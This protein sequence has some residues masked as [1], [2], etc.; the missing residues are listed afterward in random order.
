MQADEPCSN[1]GFY[2]KIVLRSGAPEGTRGVREWSSMADGQLE[3]GV[4]LNDRY[5]ILRT[6][7]QG[8]MGTVYQA[9]HERLSAILAVKEI[10]GLQATGTAQKATLDQYEQEARF[11]VRLNHPNLPKV[12]DAFVDHDRFYLVME[13]VEGVTL[14]ARFKELGARPMDP[15]KVVEWGLQIADVLAYLHSQQPPIIFRDLKPSN[16]MVQPDGGIKLID[17]GIARRFQPGADKDTSLLGSVGYSPPEQFG[18]HQTDTRSD[19]YAFGATLHHLLTAR[20]PSQT[21]FKF[22]PAQQLNPAVPE[23]L[24]KLLAQCLAME[25]DQR[26]PN[27]HLVASGLLGIRDQLEMQQRHI[28]D[29]PHVAEPGHAPS[30]KII[31][32]KLNAAEKSRPKRPAVGH[33][34]QNGAVA[35]RQTPATTPRWGRIGIAVVSLGLILGGAAFGLHALSHSRSGPRS[36]IQ[37]PPS[38][39]PGKNE[40]TVFAGGANT[41]GGGGNGGNSSSQNSTDPANGTGD[42]QKHVDVPTTAG[43][44]TKPFYCKAE[45]EGYSND[46]KSVRIHVT[47]LVKGEKGT[48]G[49]VAAYFYTADKTPL[50]AVNAQSPFA[51]KSGQLYGT[52]TFQI[53]ADEEPF[54]GTM[55]IP[56]D[57]FPSTDGVQF[58]CIV[59]ADNQSAGQTEMQPLKWEDSTDSSKPRGDQSGVRFRINPDL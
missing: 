22:P 36:H 3:A 39:L 45:V 57:Q 33:T 23:A 37:P 58:R 32:A 47:G 14:E 42:S 46:G 53:D 6:I 21:P 27:I 12:T 10:R 35:D 44:I 9:E 13:F 38:A 19:I 50:L 4:L 48:A 24:S 51:S 59:Y 52:H 30:A 40:G 41:A 8:G 31:S 17:F 2:D 25:A 20:D 26:P 55:D 1:P 34:P 28:P 11:L 29:L 5:R 7:G 16:V 54:D 43:P 49:M 18:R 56:L 15:Q